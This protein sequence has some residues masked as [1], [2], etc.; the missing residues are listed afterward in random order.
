MRS[1]RAGSSHEQ[2]GGGTFVTDG[3]M[4]APGGGGES[5]PESEPASSTA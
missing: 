1:I 2:T 3:V 5:P 4:Q